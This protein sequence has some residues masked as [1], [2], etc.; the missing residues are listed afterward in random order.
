MPVVVAGVTSIEEMA[1]AH[2][3]RWRR[4][5]LVE[6]RRGRPLPPAPGAAPAVMRFR[7][8]A[9]PGMERSVIRYDFVHL[10]DAPDELRGAQIGELRVGDEVEI[11]E[12]RGAWVYVRT[13]LEGEGWLHRTTLGPRSDAPAAEA[14]ASAGKRQTDAADAPGSSL[15]SLIADIVAN[16]PPPASGAQS[17]S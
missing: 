11:I 1:E 7:T 2:L 14:S 13:P 10:T 15:D 16:R 3:P 12:K 6:A 5:S 9:L 17:A 8:D 4:Q